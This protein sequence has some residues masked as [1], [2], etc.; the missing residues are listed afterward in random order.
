MTINPGEVKRLDSVVQSSFGLTNVGGALH[1][2]TA[3]A[4]PLVVTARTYNQTA[5]GTLGQFIP[6]FTSNDAVGINDRALQ[7]LQLEESSRYRT[8]VGLSEV[9]GKP[10]TVEVSLVLPDSKVSPKT[11]IPLNANEFRQFSVIR[12]FGLSNVYNAR[13]TVRVIG[14]DGK[15]GAYGSIVDQ[16]TEAPS[17]VPAQ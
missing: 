6:A 5:N 2:T 3:A 14:G 7:I 12:D 13:I 4:S 10:A 16:K 1:I 9:T 15:V 17:Y 8:N 11:Q